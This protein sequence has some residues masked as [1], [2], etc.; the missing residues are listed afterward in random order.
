M[1]FPKKVNQTGSFGEKRKKIFFRFC[2]P[3]L[4]IF[5][6]PLLI[7][8]VVCG[9]QYVGSTTT[10]TKFRLRLKNHKSRLRAQSAANKDKDDATYKH[11]HS[12]GPHG[13]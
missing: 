6:F 11:F 12:D 10:S 2:R 4:D 5:G 1:S 3:I 9:L 13:L 8:C 7:S